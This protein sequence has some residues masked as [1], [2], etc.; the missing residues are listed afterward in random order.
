M[1]GGD[2]ME[3]KYCKVPIWLY[4]CMWAHIGACSM[5]FIC[6]CIVAIKNYTE[7]KEAKE[8]KEGTDI[9]E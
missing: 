2:I 1:K 8:A 7:A 4:S 6:R 5:I 9:T 3:H